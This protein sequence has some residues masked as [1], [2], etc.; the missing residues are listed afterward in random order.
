MS[1]MPKVRGEFACYCGVLPK[2]RVPVSVPNL[3]D[4]E[5]HDAQAKRPVSILKKK[6]AK[7]LH[8]PFGE[9]K[10]SDALIYPQ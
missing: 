4:H 2:I 7:V 10:G 8:G 3:E 5:K 1:R 6:A 9:K